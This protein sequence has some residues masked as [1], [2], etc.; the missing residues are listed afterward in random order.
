MITL[1]NIMSK[2]MEKMKEDDPGLFRLKKMERN[3]NAKKKMIE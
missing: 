3:E 1:N 2:E